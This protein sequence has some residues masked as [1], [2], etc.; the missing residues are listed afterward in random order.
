MTA[1][2][3]TLDFSCPASAPLIDDGFVCYKI[4]AQA[5]VLKYLSDDRKELQSSGSGSSLRFIN[6]LDIFICLLFFFIGNALKKCFL[7]C[8]KGDRELPSAFTLQVPTKSSTRPM[9]RAKNSAPSSRV[10]GSHSCGFPK[11]DFPE[12]WSGE[13]G[14][15]PE[16]RTPTWD[17]RV[18]AVIFMARPNASP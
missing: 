7:T 18:P 2:G 4:R 5:V 16:P 14:A 1:R 17:E 15:V 12:S 3:Y 10:G 8:S 11:S 13:P 9:P 6:N